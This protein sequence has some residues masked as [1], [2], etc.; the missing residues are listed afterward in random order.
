M[1]G[2][3]VKKLLVIG[4]TFVPM[5]DSREDLEEISIVQDLEIV[6]CI[7]WNIQLNQS[8]EKVAA[9]LDSGSEAN[10]IS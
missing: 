3:S 7:I 5:T 9:L 1:P 10:L 6:K 4:N 8:N 2:S